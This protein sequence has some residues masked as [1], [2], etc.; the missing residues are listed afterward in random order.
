MERIPAIIHSSWHEHLQPLFDDKKMTLLRDK[1]LTSCRFYPAPVDIFKVFSMPL[2]QIKVVIIGQDPYFNGEANGLAFA[3]NENKPIPPSLKIIAK[4]IENE[5]LKSGFYDSDIAHWKTLE[6]W[7][8]QGVFLLNSA[9]TVEA[10]TPN[11]HTG[12]WQW[13]TREVIKLISLHNPCIWLLWGAKAK[14]F[15]DYIHNHV[16]LSNK[17]DTIQRIVETN[18]THRENYIFEADHPAAETYPGSKYKFTGCNHF[19]LCNQALQTT[20][21]S[22]INW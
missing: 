1:V 17:N 11:S 6:A 10:K 9:L 16:W 7:T 19:T 15:K 5:G 3:V 4:E 8:E 21:K 18:I 13:F 14:T 20:Q 12:Q 2:D 22:I